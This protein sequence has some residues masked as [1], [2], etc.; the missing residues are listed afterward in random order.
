MC[1][2]FYVQYHPPKMG[3][4][5]IGGGSRTPAH[6]LFN[7]FIRD[8]RNPTTRKATTLGQ[9]KPGRPERRRNNPDVAGI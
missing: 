7:R 6:G 1:A 4:N 9:L 2:L 5:G 3:R 8:A